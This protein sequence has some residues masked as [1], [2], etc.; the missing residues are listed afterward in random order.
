MHEQATHFNTPDV[1]PENSL[2]ALQKL[3][4]DQHAI[5]A[6]TDLSGKINYVNDL[7]CD[8]SGYTREELIGKTHRLINSGY[9][10]SAFFHEMFSTLK[11]HGLWRG[12]ICNRR[13]DGVLYWVETT[14]ATLRND[15]GEP[16]GYIAMRTDVS[17]QHRTL[18]AM[19]R[20][21]EITVDR[22]ISF[23]QKIT[24]IL[25]LGRDIFHLPLAIL[26]S[27]KVEL[28]TYT[29]THSCSPNGEISP[30]DTFKLG[31]TFCSDTVRQS[32]PIS[33]HHVG[34]SATSTHPAYENFK[35]EA[36]IGAPIISKN[37]VIGT[38]NFS[39]PAPRPRAFGNA[40]IEL[41]QLFSN[42]ISDE[43][44]RYDT[45]I[46]LE[47]QRLLLS[48]VSEQARIGAWEFDIEAE[49]LY[50]SEVTRKIHEVPE[51][52]IPTI[53][54]AIN[55]YDN[56]EAQAKI[57]ALVDE[58]I[59]S[60]TPWNVELPLT[61]AKG[62]AI[63]VLARGEPVFD[64][65]R[66]I[67]LFGSFQDITQERQN[68]AL[69][70]AQAQRHQLMVESTAVGFWDLNIQSGQ[71]SLSE[72]WAEIIGY[73]LE[74]LEPIS[75][76]TWMSFCHPD[77]LT[78]SAEK[79]ENY[80]HG[81]ATSYDCQSRVR[82]KDGY[83][84]WIHDTG[85]IVEDDADGN[86]LRMIGTRIDI[87]ETKKAQAEI[88]LIN[89]RIRLA[90]ESAGISIWEYNIET[91]E[92]TWDQGMYDL[93]QIPKETELG[94]SQWEKYFHPDDHD[95][96]TAEI[97]NAINNK[98]SFDHEFRICS[99]K[100]KVKYLREAAIVILN[101]L[102]H[103]QMM[104]G[105]TI[106]ITKEK[107]NASALIAAKKDAEQA[108]QAKSDFLAT[109]SHEIRTP[110][111]GVL[112]MLALLKNTQLSDDQI[113]RVRIAQ[114][115]AQSL[116]TLINDI[117]DFS[118]IEANKLKLESITFD[119]NQTLIDCVESL[120]SMAE[121]KGIELIIN[122]RNLINPLV[123]GDPNRIRQIL[124]NLISNAVKF[125]TTGEVK[126]SLIQKREGKSWT[127]DIKVED[128]GVGI[129]SEKISHLF[130]AFNQLDSSTTREHGGTG[131]GLAIVSNLCK[132]M[133]GKVSVESTLNKGSSFV[134]S[135]QLGLPKNKELKKVN[136][137]DKNI[138]IIEHNHN[139]RTHI[140]SHLR[141]LGAD[142]TIASSGKDAEKLIV[143][144]DKSFDLMLL[145]NNI[146]GEDWRDNA[147]KF[148]KIKAVDTALRILIVPISF[149]DADRLV[150]SGDIHQHI[151]KPIDVLGLAKRITGETLDNINLSSISTTN[152]TKFDGKR[153]LLVEDNRV[154][155]LVAEEMLTAQGMR[156]DIAENGRKA[157]DLL[158]SQNNEYDMILMD[159]QMPVMDGYDAT[160]A[161]RSGEA[162]SNNQSLPIIAMTAHAMIGDKER[163]L[164]AGMNDYLA[165]PVDPNQMLDMLSRWI[166]GATDVA[167]E[168]QQNEASAE[169][170]QINELSS[171]I[172]DKSTAL[173]RVMGNESLLLQLM[174]M[175]KD[176][177]PER[178]QAMN[179]A[180]DE[181]RFDDL[182]NQ[183]HGLKGVAGNLGLNTIKVL[184][185][186]I[187]HAIK[188]D[189][190]DTCSPLLEEL[191]TETDRFVTAYDNIDKIQTKGDIRQLKRQL[192]FISNAL[193]QNDY[194]SQKSLDFMLQ[195][196]GKPKI[197]GLLTQ[198]ARDI[199]AFE[200]EKA[201]VRLNNILEQLD[202]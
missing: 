183:A 189:K 175:F 174:D 6:M 193:N 89:Q 91:G 143:Y 43:F 20:L 48:S 130:N 100:G 123:E 80:L 120:A 178:L 157:I 57:S 60:G 195:T 7:F 73:E 52:F 147:S 1:K 98:T 180:I 85:R 76:D 37:C 109:M 154:N 18:E 92:I 72:R 14:I 108:T 79:L 66:C 171:D 78:E 185:E 172:W 9:H 169:M 87:S 90:T 122:T 156:V 35:L 198:L 191:C 141:E 15:N 69:Q 146:P 101:E 202:G 176:E 68:K 71:T 112:G 187:E 161:I 46:E 63:W 3:A 144:T 86:P 138:L 75:I 19:R 94:L 25:E 22:S 107:L 47:R 97:K 121:S 177:Q 137:E 23:D 163:C 164:A 77:D 54:N 145:D 142:V 179:S 117:L 110:M 116:L 41:I 17:E 88:H 127:L 167:Q 53:E 111:N 131:L 105:I 44:T 12:E 96:V 5:V 42:W 133:N 30:G 24:H 155:Q 103:A 4:F 153:I 188:Q 200:N 124:T 125:T 58:A 148:A 197:E 104:V 192:N 168:L 114:N 119:I 55:F 165:K 95:W 21:H 158:C 38:I 59:V 149:R 152:R 32:Q 81:N 159:C 134:A 118:K 129:A 2:W 173:N 29:V 50:W 150:D 65:G 140:E 201:Q 33:H 182:K 45:S 132:R 84:V 40:E 99:N 8:I 13:K 56:A 74:E 190:I 186:K 136:L 83:W 170:L 115:S 31:D 28:D 162:G 36:Y 62:S 26:S 39:G 67:K 126:V 113:N 196:Y 10:D 160:R 151:F 11:E 102:G 34:K 16:S 181:N 139:T 51:S 93:Y 166:S 135:I 184:A 82:H 194:I 128:T 199:T 106:D 70:Y 61:T 27:I 49:E 64:Q